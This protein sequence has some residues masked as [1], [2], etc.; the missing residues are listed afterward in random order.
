MHR[1][2]LPSTSFQADTV[3][4]PP[5]TA[6]QISRVLRL[7]PGQEVVT[8]DGSGMEFTTR[9]EEVSPEVAR[10]V[11]TAKAICSAEP[12]LDLVVYLG[13]T[14]REKMEWILQKCTEV[15]AAAF[16]PVV[17]SRSLVQDPAEVEHKRVRWENI[18]REAAEQCGR[19]RIPVLQACLRFPQALAQS[20]QFENALLCWEGEHALSLSKAVTGRKNIGVFIG[21]EGGFS[22]EEAAAAQAAGW[23][24]VTLGKRIL[25]M[26]T[27]AVV[28]CALVL[29]KVGE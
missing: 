8:L 2:F 7:Q 12:E 27:A 16:I 20:V 3:I 24:P 21:P 22:T 25:R 15:G 18:L 6:R 28:A 9:L 1:F 19:G 26:E 11:V 4:F 29:E 17:T 23:Q 10:G 14:Q 5:E 13:H